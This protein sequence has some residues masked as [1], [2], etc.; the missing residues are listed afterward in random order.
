MEKLE[1][2]A[3]VAYS[4]LLVEDLGESDEEKNSLFS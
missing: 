1:E 2:G 3:S 4:G